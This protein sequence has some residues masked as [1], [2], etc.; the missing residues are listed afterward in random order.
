MTKQQAIDTINASFPSIWSKDDV[1]Q[2]INK[3]D[4]GE[5]SIDREKLL[6]KIK[7]AVESGI[8]GMSNDEIVDKSECD[9]DVRN[10]NEI[11]LDSFGI[12]TSDIVDNVMSDVENA[13][14]E[15]IEELNEKEE[16]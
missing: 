11:V 15:Y 6:E 16:A 4:E 14:D 13:I 1:L 2:L 9:F 10:G 5:G 8:E 7:E 3:I 12:N